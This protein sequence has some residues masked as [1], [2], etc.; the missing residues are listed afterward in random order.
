MEAEKIVKMPSMNF[1]QKVPFSTAKKI[2]KKSRHH[3]RP[4]GTDEKLFPLPNDFLINDSPVEDENK[5]E[6]R[7]ILLPAPPQGRFEPSRRSDNAQ[8]LAPDNKN[9]TDLSR[10]SNALADSFFHQQKAT[11][12]KNFDFSLSNV[13]SQP[14]HNNTTT[15]TA[16]AIVGDVTR[17]VHSAVPMMIERLELA[18]KL[19]EEQ[20]K[21]EMLEAIRHEQ[22]GTDDPDPHLEE[23]R[24]EIENKLAQLA[25][26]E[27][28]HREMLAHNQHQQETEK[29]TFV[30]E[31][32]SSG[33]SPASASATVPC[34]PMRRFIRLF[35]V[36]NPRQWIRQNCQLAKR[37]FPNASC[38]QVEALLS[39]CVQ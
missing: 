10:N 2:G 4:K 37:H 39:K 7:V 29:G 23:R 8:I 38:V 36:D 34:G 16:T 35:R 24:R 30:S 14:S 15:S 22:L 28:I 6:G 27:R 11:L 9:E 20:V 19:R 32:G 26:S 21:L 33:T 18:R 3:H 17:K 5:A 31:L 12:N 13:T 25:Q 1:S